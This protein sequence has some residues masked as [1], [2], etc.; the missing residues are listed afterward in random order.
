MRDELLKLMSALLASLSAFLQDYGLMFLAGCCVRFSISLG[1]AELPSTRIFI[2]DMLVSGISGL[3]GAM[4][5]K[6]AGSGV[7]GVSVMLISFAALGSAG[8][9]KLIKTVTDKYLKDTEEDGK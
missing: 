8:F 5:A 6:E 1:E 9:K 2:S 3:L 4:I 7:F